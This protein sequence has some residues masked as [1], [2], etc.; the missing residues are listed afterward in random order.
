M[1]L[2]REIQKLETEINELGAE[3]RSGQSNSRPIL[4]KL[5]KAI[6]RKIELVE[7]SRLVESTR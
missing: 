7:L 4:A 6:R 1:S 5:R 2:Q 3:F